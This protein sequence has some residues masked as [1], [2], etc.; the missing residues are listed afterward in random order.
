MTPYYEHGGITIYHG[1]CRDVLADMPR[2][3]VDLV[4]TDP[5][6]PKEYDHVWDAL[7]D[8]APPVM[9]DG[10]SLMTYLGHYQLPRVLAAMGRNLNYQWLCFQPNASGINPIMYGFRVKVNYKPVLW[11]VKGRFLKPVIL[12][13]HLGRL[14]RDWAK[15]LHAW[16]QPIAPQPILKLT[17]EGGVVLDPFM[18]SGTVMRAAKDLGRYGIGIEIDERYCEIA[19]DRLAQEML[20]LEP[21]A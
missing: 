16:A 1:D 14:G 17:D 2:E 4:F 13:D 21:V 18:G 11:Y 6:Y 9:R 8:Y 20:P 15:R 3:S 7:A 10:A 5:P 19:A 12:D